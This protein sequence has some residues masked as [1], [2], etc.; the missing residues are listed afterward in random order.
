MQCATHYDAPPPPRAGCQFL[1]FVFEPALFTPSIHAWKIPS[2]KGEQPGK[3]KG[4][5][6]AKVPTG[7]LD[8]PLRPPSSP[9]VHPSL[10]EISCLMAQ[11]W[12]WFRGPATQSCVTSGS[13][14]RTAGNPWRAE[15]L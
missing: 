2:S 15:G 7:I 3:L 6:F 13:S 9:P 14:T 12:A 10:I 5:Y 4:Y 1:A 8:Q 11:H